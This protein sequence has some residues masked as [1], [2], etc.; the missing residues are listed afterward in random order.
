MGSP[1]KCV[2]VPCQ[3][4]WLAGFLT[5]LT[6]LSS[7]VGADDNPWYQD[8]CSYK[9]E[10]IDEDNKVR[11][12]LKLCD[13]S[14]N[15]ACGDG[16]AICAQNM[17]SKAQRSVGDQSQRTVSSSVLDFSSSQNCGEGDG[18]VQSSI[19]FQ[20][21]KTMGT[22]EFVTES[23]CV[24]YFEW[25]TYVACRKDKFKPHKEVPCY[26][27]DG[28]GKKH[29][30][31][32][33]IKLT[34]GYLVDDSDDEIDLYINIC[35]SITSVDT[36]CPDG[37]AACLV[38]SKGKFNVGRPTQQLELNAADRLRLH[39]DGASDG[40]PDFCG[41]HTPA[42]TVTFICP[43]RRQEASNPRM[44]AKTN[45]R[46]E[47]EW[48][49]EY[50][51]HR[52]Y[53]ESSNCT[54]T[55]EQHDIA[56]DLTHLTLGSGENP[57]YV[58]AKSKDGKDSYTY[59]L[60]VCGETK[61]GD[62]TD[63]AGYVSVCQ[64]KDTGDV[65]K[66]AG[67]Y[68]NQ[69][70]RYSDGDLTLIYPGGSACSSGFQRMTIINFECNRTAGNDGKGFPVFTGE[71][72]CTYYF[73][74]HTA[75]ACVKEKEDLLC[76]VTSNKKHY[77]LSPL[78]RYSLSE[79]LQNWEAVDGNAP[80]ADR[81]RFYINVCH[82][83]L[84]QGVTSG[85]PEEAAICAVGKDKTI[86]LGKFLSPP[87]MDDNNIRLTYTEG[88]ECRSN[89]KIKTIITLICK[90]GD[91][92]SA[93]LLKSESSDGCV[94]EFEWFTAAACV[95]SKSEGDNCKV[96][97]PLAGFS[98]DLSPLQKAEGMYNISSGEY[99]YFVNVCDKVTAAKCPDKAGA[100]QV[101]KSGNSWSLGEFNSKLSYYDGMIQLTYRNG[102]QYNNKQHTQRSTL[103]SFL[104]DRG[105]GV[106]KP[107]YQV[108]DD[109]TYNFRWY[110][111]YACPE[112]PQECVVTDPTTLLQYDLSS[113]ARSD[114]NGGKNWLAMDMSDTSNLRKYYIN[115]CRPL[116]PVT[117]CD[118]LASVCEMKYELDQGGVSEK[119][120]ISNMGVAK[121]GPVIEEEGRLLLE[122][123]DGSACVS[124]GR[125]TTYTTR[126]HMVC[127]QGAVSSGPRFIM[128]QNCT[129][130]FLWHTRAACPISSTEVTNQ[131]CT[132]KDPSTGF[133]FNLL[134]LSNETGYTATGNG[135]TF[136]VNLCGPVTKCGTDNGK[137][138]A[139]CEMENGQP[140]G[141]VGVE[142]SLQLSTDGVLT[143]TYKGDLN[144]PTGTRDTFTISFVCDQNESPG[145]LRLLREEMSSATQVTH[146]V[147]F[148]FRTAL[149]CMP[150]PVECQLTDSRGNEYDLSDLSR[151]DSPWVAIDTS[152][153]A[154]TRSFYINVCKPLP[155]VM[156]CPGGALGSCAKIGNKG[157][158]LGYVQS[159]PQAAADGSISIVYLN[160]DKCGDG[161]YSTRII[162]QCDDSPGSP[163]FESLNNCEYVFIWRTS[164]ACPVRR[165][166]GENC[167]VRDPRSGY[168]FDLT[169]LSGKDY[170]VKESQY[171][172]HF[173]VCGPLKQRVCT[174]KDTGS[175]PVS[176][177]QVE[178]KVHRIA[179][180]ATQ[181]LIFDDG[182]IMINYTHGERCHKVY[183]RSTAIL[184]SCDHSKSVGAPEFIRETPDCTY[185]FEWHTSLAC[186]PFKTTSCSFNDD[187]G[188][189][190]DLSSLSLP[191]SNWEVETKTGSKDRYYINVCK[192]LVPQS[193]AWNCPSSAASC[194]KSS[195]RYVSLGE[196]ESGLRWEKNVLVLRY[197]NGENCTDGVRKRTTIIRF[198]CDKNKVDS[199]PTLITAIEE[200]VYTFMWFTAAACPLQS[201]EHG[202]CRVT[203]PVT[204][205]QFDLS[206]LRRP[207]GYTVYD[208]ADRRKMFRLNVCG[209]AANMGCEEG[210]GVCIK[211]SQSAVSGGKFSQTL[212][213]LDKVVQ[214]TY[215]GGAVCAANP[216]YRHKSV[217]SF[218]CKSEG[219]ASDGPVLVDT[220]AE[221]CVHF[222]SWHTPLVCEEKVKCS[223]WNGSSLIDLNPLIHKTGY[224]TATDMDLDD[225]SPDFYIN[226]CQPLNPIPGVNCPPGVAVCMDPADGPP[227]DIGRIA[228]P[229]QINEAIG[230]VYI[231]FNSNTP[232]PS[233]R[234]VNYSSL[235][236]F[237]C[238]R[239]T[240]LGTPQMIR[241]SNCHYVFEWATPVV[242]SDSVTTKGCTLNDEQL[243]FTFNLSSLTG[244]TFQVSSA[245]GTYKINVCGT[246]PD[247]DC[248]DSA[249]CLASGSSKASFGNSKAMTMDY[250][251]EDEAVI[252]QY[253]SGDPCPPVTV[254]GEACI[255]P[256]RFQG[257]SYSSCTTNGRTD[258]Q[259]WCA[260]TG[261]YD[262]D[263]L[264]GFC[265]NAKGQGQRRSSILFT[266]D[267]AGGLG[268]PQLL[269]ETQGCATT[270]QWATSAVCP[271]RKMECKLV[272]QHK[273]YDLRTLSSLTAPWRF[274]HDGDSYYM[275][276]C[277]GIYGGVTGCPEGAT[278]C[279][280]KRDGST[281]SL[282]R[283]YTQTMGI[284]ADKVI[285]VNYTKGDAAC[286][287]DRAAKT[288]IQLTCGH[289]VGSPKLVRV[290]EGACEFW[291][292]WETRVACA[293]EQQEVEMINGT[294]RVPDTGA[295]F[296]L[297]ALYYRLHQA[298]GDIR[299]NGDRYIYDIQL[300]GITNSSSAF[301]LGANICQVK[302]NGNLQRKIGSSNKAKYFIKDGNLDVLVPSDS[303]C[304]RDMSKTVSSTILFHCSP[305]AGEGIPEFLLETDGCQ[306][307][308]IW[309]TSTVCKLIA[310]DT[311]RQTDEGG[312]EQAGLSGRSQAV[313]AVLSVLLVVL[314][315]C[316]IILLL[317][318]RE[319]RELVIQKVTGCCRRGNN[320]SYKYS[321][322]NT[323][324][325][326]GEDE[327]EWLMEEIEPPD[328][329]SSRLR[330]EAQENGHITT[331]P[332][333]AEALRSFPLDE[334][335]SE[336]EVLTVPGVRVQT[337]RPA[338]Q[339]RRPRR[340][341]EESDEDLVGLLDEGE[342]RGRPQRREQPR[343]KRADNPAS[344][345]DDSDEDLLKV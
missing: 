31:N 207:E 22:P 294:I 64:V 262:K 162:F 209:E 197:T 214:L 28:D 144:K 147:F 268:T 254:N 116:T 314:T 42:V 299:T 104:C 306:Y 45:C 210:T 266:C 184:F 227:V 3:I 41:E 130:T 291:V 261:D 148:E 24:H 145:T 158:N 190:Y 213:Y 191:R 251:H 53:L 133:E 300:S 143:L 199:M 341:Q 33:L 2:P 4:V 102:S 181:N 68:K 289:T 233:N 307:L 57:Y 175:D 54:L 80:E 11:Y 146:D 47:V 244:R 65:R 311:S 278:V 152:D 288:I 34:D 12:T 43:S 231:P 271:P 276:L 330:K 85:C 66:I 180:L 103:I 107:E 10:A 246:L 237:S 226:I 127:Q 345:H 247:A 277:Q 338:P 150:A 112:R 201:S 13:S 322:V 36:G 1:C 245:S 153:Q 89:N 208:R 163:M 128:N 84:Q 256:F 142:R 308:F 16:V 192:S 106:G 51:C 75:Y 303:K 8:L 20:C 189:S 211:D 257:K 149:A 327:M 122:Y 96:A 340:A 94:Y 302:I 206:G 115:V 202:D 217:F 258:G 157:V 323:E 156:G 296:S 205:H 339:Q 196:V 259:L 253:G 81:K 218:V 5:L 55:S 321:K 73:D 313:G 286:G 260:T 61:A 27:F 298:S 232:C 131:T 72:D 301:C 30:L 333:N 328:S 50:A 234:S 58:A 25:R 98:F 200:C 221:K 188:N 44:T 179:G 287:N 26:V 195:D 265:Q 69:T 337:G 310:M 39:Y 342:R 344:F 135:K 274:S 40:K 93:P 67:R 79:T 182:L 129:A 255:F 160:G 315:A 114:R 9:W 183:E 236:V 170:E 186:L 318:K 141:L 312:E 32:P 100:C 229:P 125:T 6:F 185:L 194:L 71:T 324:E 198:K 15:T 320:V 140:S 249:V 46:Y 174:H 105:A 177:C 239:G 325:E 269:S 242:C 121:K 120:S 165:V 283:V 87:K 331:K 109:Y 270:F 297:G 48:V 248:K 220:D 332:V 108:E 101:D 281:K 264:W 136:L 216:A 228:S 316:L 74:W 92:E 290:D 223:V 132:V 273:T 118:R 187:Q 309:H 282:G 335:D 235:I 124:E 317:H 14:P 17:S 60:N 168:V 126:I 292:A 222:F 267:P 169:P 88:G 164:E 77:D 117:G 173:A 329:S 212:S 343:R 280:K 240:E 91:L 263:K 176:S 151:D 23:K 123:T 35:R 111:S 293:V 52:D 336:D 159:S 230:E 225:N 99:T 19:S 29:D 319:R 252:M 139:G 204:G 38:T 62:C 193:G 21:G 63:S 76:R 110:T 134:P 155:R 250:R 56:I 119:V 285:T 82:K 113:L 154:K 18:K 304:G 86:S 167:K 284:G 241:K 334:Q 203:N 279:R 178:D 219:V 78:T 295:S 272:H 215:E 161:R 243:Q 171:D 224:Y 70:L 166:Q 7:A 49:T 275:N 97:D 90:P 83:I 305:S 37:A 138:V 59:Y 326:G 172:Y 95:L 238:Q 137:P